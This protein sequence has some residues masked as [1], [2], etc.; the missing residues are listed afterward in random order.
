MRWVRTHEGQYIDLDKAFEVGIDTNVEQIYV[1]AWFLVRGT[2]G[3][4]IRVDIKR[5]S[6]EEEAKAF[7]HKLM[8]E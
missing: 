1:S 7:L 8:E 3:T 2:D 6:D 4:P 5:F